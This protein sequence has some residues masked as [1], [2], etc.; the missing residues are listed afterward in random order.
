VSTQYS[1]IQKIFFLETYIRKTA[2]KSEVE[3]LEYGSPVC[4]VFSLEKGRFW[5]LKETIYNTYLKIRQDLLHTPFSPWFN[6]QVLLIIED[7]RSHSDTLYSVRLLWTSDHSDAG[8][9][10]IIQQSLQVDIHDPAGF[11]TQNPKKKAIAVPRFR[12]RSHLD[13]LYYYYHHHHHH[14]HH[15]H[16]HRHR[17]RRRRHYY[18]YHYHYHHHHHHHHHHRYII[19]KFMAIK[20]AVSLGSVF[21]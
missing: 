6:S 11:R 1:L 10:D 4:P 5:E 20:F 12:P 16:R 2:H 17:R 18:H 14:H 8:T 15:H 3:N 19:R 9:S 13:R 7:S 21:I